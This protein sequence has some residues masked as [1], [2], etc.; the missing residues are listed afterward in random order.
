MAESTT[1]GPRPTERPPVRTLETRHETTRGDTVRGEQSSLSWRSIFGGLAVGVLAYLALM[2][3]GMAFGGMAVSGI[4]DGGLGGLGTGTA[5]WVILSAIVS[6][7]VGGY[8]AAR[9]SRPGSVQIGAA[10][11]AVV[12]GLFFVLS[13]FQVGNMLGSVTSG[14]SSA[15]STAA[16][17]VS[18]IAGSQQAQQIVQEAIGENTQLQAPPQEV[19]QTV[20]VRL[21]T[22]DVQGAKTYLSNQTNLS[23]QEIDQAVTQIQSRLQTVAAGATGQIGSAIEAAGWALFIS[24]VLGS[25][26]ALGGGAAGGRASHRKPYTEAREERRARAA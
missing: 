15:V 17:W 9:L 14:V 19:L 10:H 6:L 21:V 13:L 7:F 1:N 4:V 2:S 24:I 20:A 16:N 26:A 5:V 25:A 22:G 11:G 8:F 23:P 12:A 18:D 3:L